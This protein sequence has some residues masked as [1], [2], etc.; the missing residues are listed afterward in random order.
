M[1]DDL[2]SSMYVSASGMRSQGVRMRLSSENLANSESTSETPGG[3]PY[4]RRIVTFQ[5]TLDRTLNIERVRVR[6]IVND[7][8]SFPIEY[9]PSHPSADEN[10]YVKMPNV[11]TLI[12]L[13]DLKEANRSYE[14]NLSAIQMARS[15][16]GKTIEIL[17]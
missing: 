5:N 4:R 3:D 2:I 17:R 8:S 6:D 16:L 12:E 13:M 15:M 14:A 1:S 9:D 7:D 10:G 11:N